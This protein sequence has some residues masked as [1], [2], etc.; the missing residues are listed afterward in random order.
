MLAIELLRG[1]NRTVE[2]EF[3]LWFP[4]AGRLSETPGGALIDAR[5]R[6][7]LRGNQADLRTFALEWG[8]AT[9][10]RMIE[11]DTLLVKCPNCGAWPMAA[12]PSA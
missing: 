3:P 2:D 12:G 6:R 11:T 8:A 7:G 1:I 4:G 5:G 10:P 9:E